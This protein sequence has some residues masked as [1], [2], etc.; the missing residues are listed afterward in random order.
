MANMFAGAPCGARSC[1]G[2]VV[3]EFDMPIVSGRGRGHGVVGGN[4]TVK[5]KES[6]IVFSSPDFPNAT[7]GAGRA[8]LKPS[9]QTVERSVETS[10]LAAK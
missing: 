7:V 1:P 6:S 8:S 4:Y 5:W 2:S 3:A 10:I 9:D